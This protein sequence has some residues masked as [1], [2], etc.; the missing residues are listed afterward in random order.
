MP[1]KL[2]GLVRS[3]VRQPEGSSTTPVQRHRIVRRWSRHS[4]QRLGLV[5]RLS[6]PFARPKA[7]VRH[8]WHRSIGGSC[9][10]SRQ[11]SARFRW[12]CRLDAS[13]RV[14]GFARQRPLVGCACSPVRLHSAQQRAACRGPA[15]GWAR[16]R[17]DQRAQVPHRHAV[18]GACGGA[19]GSTLLHHLPPRPRPG[20]RQSSP[21]RGRR[22]LSQRSIGCRRCKRRSAAAGQRAGPRVWRDCHPRPVR[23][24]APRHRRMRRLNQRVV[25]RL[26]TRARRCHALAGL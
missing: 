6:H 21:R 11:R 25:A 4:R 13:T 1:P 5:A 2:L 23:C 10:A 15:Q 18:G 9:H 26:A 19:I 8:A 14:G 7:C 20:P 16:R 3:A 12:R 22:H 17:V 24:P